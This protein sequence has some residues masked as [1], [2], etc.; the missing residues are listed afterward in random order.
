M[1]RKSS[2]LKEIRKSLR[3]IC[4]LNTKDQAIIDNLNI[5]RDEKDKGWYINTKTSKDEKIIGYYND[6]MSTD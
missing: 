1:V 6:N 5:D 4:P 2:E 3:N